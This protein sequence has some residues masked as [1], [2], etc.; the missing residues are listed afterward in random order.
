MIINQ[1]KYCNYEECPGRKRSTSTSHWT[2]NLPTG[3]LR[4]GLHGACAEMLKR[5]AWY[6]HMAQ[7]KRSEYAALCKNPTSH[8]DRWMVIRKTEGKEHWDLYQD[9]I[10]RLQTAYDIVTAM[11]LLEAQKHGV[12]TSS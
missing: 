1:G 5:K 10:E 11:N 7:E 4:S 2:K 3:E 9:D 6:E 8:G 12:I